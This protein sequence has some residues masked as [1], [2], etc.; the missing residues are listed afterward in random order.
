MSGFFAK[1][2]QYFASEVMVKA[3]AN[4][5][6][7]QRFAVKTDAFLNTNMKNVKS[8]GTETLNTFVKNG[9]KVVREQAA[10]AVK[11]AGNNGMFSKV[12]V[13]AKAIQNEIKKDLKL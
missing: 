9:E 6:V 2:V 8:V 12:F 7:F 10:N 4:S 13:Y 3:L 11:S 5:K 1:L